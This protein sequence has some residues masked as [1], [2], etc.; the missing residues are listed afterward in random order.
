MKA[1]GSIRDIPASTTSLVTTTTG[2]VIYARALTE[3]NEAL[4]LSPQYSY[5]FNTRGEVYENKGEFD[6][7]LADFRAALGLDPDKRQRAG[8]EA[9]EGIARIEQ[10]LAAIGGAGQGARRRRTARMEF[11]PAHV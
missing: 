3:V 8:L 10:K 11:P 6:K 1:F 4:R 7:A 2:R 9:A 5:A